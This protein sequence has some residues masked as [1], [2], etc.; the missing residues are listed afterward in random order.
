MARH[1]QEIDR[2]FSKTDR[3]P[4]GALI[5]AALI[6]TAILVPLAIARAIALMQPEQAFGIV[7]VVAAVLV[8]L[9]PAREREVSTRAFLYML[10]AFLAAY[11]IWPP[12]VAI[13]L[14][15]L[16][17][18]TP[19][20]VLLMVLLAGWIFIAGTARGV[21]RRLFERLGF[22]KT[23]WIALLVLIVFLGL[24]IPYSPEPAVAVKAF[25][26]QCISLFLP[27]IVAVTLIESERDID[28]IARV[29][30]VTAVLIGLTVVYE[31]FTRH[32]I[33]VTYLS[34]LVSYRADWLDQILKPAMRMNGKFRT[35]G[36]FTVPL[37]QAEFF[38]LL[39][40]FALYAFDK[41]K[42]GF[43][44]FGVLLIA[45]LFEFA[46]IAADSRT[47]MVTSVLLIGLF[48]ILRGAMYLRAHPKAD[49]GPLVTLL[50]SFVALCVPVA[51]IAMLVKLGLGETL[52]EHGTRGAQLVLGIPKVLGRPFI[53]YGPGIGGLVLGYR[54]DG[55]NLTIDNYYLGIVLDG[56][57]PAFFAFVTLLGWLIITAIRGALRSPIERGR[58]YLM[59]LLYFIAFAL[60][61]T[62]LS[63][64]DNLSLSYIMMGVFAAYHGIASKA[65][66][67]EAVEAGLGDTGGK[68]R[69]SRAWRVARPLGNA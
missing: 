24:A 59:F 39:M 12:Y 52:G 32:N 23:L 29:L 53:G 68:K 50:L 19:A 38:T 65:A 34:K 69:R 26:D 67:Q 13:S 30:L 40:P 48:A 58:I 56:G 61:R 37:S 66:Q 62:T 21:H 14:P 6:G 8:V 25:L 27:L 42:N 57:L 11:A 20:R 28:L 51:L 43:V 64:S 36:P 55:V 9:M 15:F 16:P 33:F 22:A 35:Q 46:I 3:R 2:P 54:P 1:R 47:A 63:Q 31:A 5:V 18:I 44:R 60:V 4:Q 17:F 41:A 49:L 7:A 45:A 10:A